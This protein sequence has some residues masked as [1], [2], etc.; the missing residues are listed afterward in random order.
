VQWWSQRVPSITRTDYVDVRIPV[1]DRMHAKRL[2]AYATLGFDIPKK[3]PRTAALRLRSP[4]DKSV[5]DAS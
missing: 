2:P 5:V 3:R 4:V 1:L